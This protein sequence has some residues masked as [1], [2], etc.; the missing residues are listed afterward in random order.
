MAEIL[1]GGPPV[2]DAER[3]VIA[4]LR[5]H[6]PAHWQVLHNLEVPGRDE[7]F[8]VDVIVLTGHAVCVIDVKGAHGRIEVSGHRWFPQ[9]RAPYH[10]PVAKLRGHAKVI[11]GLIERRHPDLRTVYV[12]PLVVLAATD[13]ALVDPDNRDAPDVTTLPELVGVLADLDAA[14]DRFDRDLTS[15]ARERIVRVLDGQLRRPAG[16]PRIGTWEVIEELGGD[17]ADETPG[18]APGR[19]PGEAAVTEYR[20]RNIAAPAGS[21]PVRLRVYRADPYLPADQRTAQRLRIGNAYEALSRMP[22]HRNIV[23]ARHFTPVDDGSR[24][25]LELEDVPGHALHLHLSDP[26][27]A[28]GADAT[29]RLLDDLLAGLAHAHANQV[30]HRALSPATVLVA[31]DGRGLLTGF[32][33]ARAGGDRD[34]TVADALPGAVD[35]AYRPPEWADTPDRLTSAGDVYAAGVIGYQMLTGEL[36]AAG[37]GPRAAADLATGLTTGLTGALTGAGVPADLVG[38]LRQMCAADPAARP[39]AVAALRELRRCTGGAGGTPPPPP[40]PPPPGRAGGGPSPDYRNLPDGYQLTHKYTVRRTLGQG[41]SGVAYQVYDMLARTDRAIKLVLANREPALERLRRE[42]Q[43]LL[44]L[45]PHPNLVRVRDADFLPDGEVPYLAFD[46]VEGRAVNALVSDDRPLGPADVRR[47]GMD[48]AHGLTYLHDHGVYHCDIKPSN[49]LWTDDGCRILDFDVAV[50]A[51]STLRHGGGSTRYLPPDLS[52]A[53]PPVAADLIDRDVYALGLTLYQ[54][55]TG[56]YPWQSATA[57]PDE[58]PLD[59]R[60]LAGLGGLSPKLVTTL[61]AAIAPRRADRYRSATDLR[62]ALAAVDEFWLPPPVP[63]PAIGRPELV[64][65]AEQGGGTEGAEWAGGAGRV[66]PNTN[67]F[68]TFLQ[69]LYS[70]SER[71]NRGTRGRDPSDT[72]LYVATALDSRLLPE[73][74]AGRHR[75]VIISGNAGDGKTAFAEHVVDQAR[76][77]GAVFGATRDNGA[78]FTLAGRTFHTNHDGSQ[79]EGERVNDDVLAEFFAPFSGSD[80]STWPDRETRLIAINEGRLVDFLTVHA[81]RFGRLA[82]LARTGIAGTAGIADTDPADPAKPAEPA[83]SADG[84]TVVNLNGRSVVA[85]PDGQHGSI[86]DLVLERLTDTNFWAACQ[87]CDLAAACYARHNA[88]TF[89][90]PAAGPRVRARLRTL[91]TLAHLRGRLHITLRDLRSALAFTLTSGRGCAGIHDLY[92]N[93]DAAAILDSFYFTSW[94]GQTG[95]TGGTAGGSTDRLLSELREIDVAGVPAPELDRQLD[96]AGPRDGTAMMTFDLRSGH[97]R[98][99]LDGMFQRLPRATEPDATEPNAAHRR[100]LATARR[101][102]FFECQDDQ[103]WRRLLPYRSAEEFLDLLAHPDRV[104]GWLPELIAAVNQGEGLGDAGTDALALQVRRVPAGTI[105]GYRLFP[106]RNLRLAATGAA[107]SR[108]LESAHN[109]V[110]LRYQ[111]PEGGRAELRLRLDLFELVRRLRDGYLPGVADMQGG[112]LSLS[113]FRNTLSALPYQEILLTVTGHDRY[114]IRRASTGDSGRL[115][116]ETLTGPQPEVG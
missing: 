28:L 36:P 12:R 18:A 41:A 75:L 101:R 79:D 3:A 25:V 73:L 48:V 113:V 17:P 103:R 51:D 112:Y 11:K 15:A 93:G 34:H 81:A 10:S 54:V 45:D 105:R 83:G 42:Y 57:P 84:V 46:Y 98:V 53:I 77:R 39:G 87:S 88:R 19:A 104:P 96:Y 94:T 60:E 43:I 66:E 29:L 49:L 59:P 13:A 99:L 1:G 35:A 50:T 2:N 56:C 109:A 8:E 30:I 31:S 20:A 4:H 9:R 62:D 22:P 72:D 69:T 102:F 24:F 26:R 64:H 116:M 90:H 100:Y 38:L 85:D 63:S 44:G 47:L 7:T 95:G 86:F 70:Q 65:I 89:S 74:L 108:Y 58:P 16:P 71:S 52:G 37:P 61:L 55:L 91:Y 115:V 114:R 110:T 76:R 80:A 92:A 6:A 82:E 40:P 67:P 68:V 27:L 106:A 23:P 21:R 32:D 33:H 78:D 5:D 14:P 97:D 111:D 107:A